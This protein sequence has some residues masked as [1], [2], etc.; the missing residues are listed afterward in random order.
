MRANA[1]CNEAGLSVS[2]RL[3]FTLPDPGRVYLGAAFDESFGCDLSSSGATLRS[4]RFAGDVGFDILVGPLVFRPF[5]TAGALTRFIPLSSVMS[6]CGTPCSDI[7]VGQNFA[8]LG[9]G[10]AIGVIAGA[11]YLSVE[12]RFVHALDTE[13]IAMSVAGTVGVRVR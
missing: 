13:G 1:R 2:V 11:A 5:M 9:G 12:G 4:R 7:I 10:L 3:G 6:G 8:A